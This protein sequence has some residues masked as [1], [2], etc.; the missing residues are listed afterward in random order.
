LIIFFIVIASGLLGFE[1]NSIDPSDII[2]I[3]IQVKP[4]T[5]AELAARGK[6]S[7][8]Y[9]TLEALDALPGIGPKTAERII[10]WREQKAYILS[11]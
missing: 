9:G 1:R 8:Q 11:E 2:P 3:N 6:L 5:L 4:G 7:L 10:R